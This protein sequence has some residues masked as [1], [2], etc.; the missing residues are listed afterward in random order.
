[1][2]MTDGDTERMR[3]EERKTAEDSGRQWKTVEEQWKTRQQKEDEDEARSD[4]EQGE[5]RPCRVVL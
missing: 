5:H 3:T 4:D 2:W 1:M